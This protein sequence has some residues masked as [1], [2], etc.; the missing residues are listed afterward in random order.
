MYPLKRVQ[1]EFKKETSEA[2]AASSNYQLLRSRAVAASYFSRLQ[3]ALHQHLI[4]YEAQPSPVTSFDD[5]PISKEKFFWESGKLSPGRPYFFIKPINESGWLFEQSSCGW[6]ISFCEKIVNENLFLRRYDSWDIVNL[7]LQQ[8]AQDHCRISCNQFGDQLLSFK[9]YEL[10]M[11]KAIWNI[12]E[13]KQTPENSEEPT[14]L[15]PSL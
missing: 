14:Y 10:K 5:E 6:T 2:L 4:A 15:L 7:Y 11:I 1:S 12:D 9:V 8:G 3:K 13:G